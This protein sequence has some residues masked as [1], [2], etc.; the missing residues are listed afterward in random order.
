[1]PQRHSYSLVAQKF[2]DG[3]QILPGHYEL[4]RERVAED[5]E[6]EDP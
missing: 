4:R 1:M 6:N 3:R 5:G 2:L